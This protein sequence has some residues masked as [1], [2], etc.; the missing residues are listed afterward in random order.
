M[1]LF[2][3][4]RIFNTVHNKQCSMFHLNF[5]DD[6]FW[7]ADLRNRK[8][9]RCQLSHNLNHC[10]SYLT[11]QDLMHR[12]RINLTSDDR[13]RVAKI[14]GG[15]FI[16]ISLHE[17]T[18]EGLKVAR[19]IRGKKTTTKGRLQNGP[20]TMAQAY[21]LSQDMPVSVQYYYHRVPWFSSHWGRISWEFGL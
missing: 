3:Y 2:L 1:P 21:K 13:K 8:R 5:A 15:I 7:T 17:R 11:L 19:N 16:Q 9:P 18:K 12:E 10:R 4:F 20:T 14:W 6:G